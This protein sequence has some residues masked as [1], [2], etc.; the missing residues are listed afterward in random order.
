[1]EEEAP[2]R[3]DAK[4]RSPYRR[5]IL[6]ALFSVT[7]VMPWAEQGSCNSSTRVLT[8]SEVMSKTPALLLPLVLIFVG[9]ALLGLMQPK[10]RR[11]LAGLA[12]E[13][14]SLVLSCLGSVYCL[15]HAVIGN[16]FQRNYYVGPWIA[17]FAPFLMAIDA[18]QG[19]VDRITQWIQERNAP[20][21]GPPTSS[22]PP[23]RMSADS[24]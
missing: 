4:R 21:G 16:M 6:L 24:D 8:G 2:H 7:L 23:V 5:A 12:L 20:P 13:V 15:V 9:P 1:M 22:E 18:T 3:A 14:S 19:I 11:A 17:F 10:I